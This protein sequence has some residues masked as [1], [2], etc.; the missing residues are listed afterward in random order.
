MEGLQTY[1]KL[2]GRHLALLIVISK[3]MPK[4]G[5]LRYTLDDAEIYE[6]FL[7]NKLGVKKEDIVTLIDEK[8]T[9][10]EIDYH[11]QQM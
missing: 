2:R 4:F 1:S 8:A 9:A 6:K 7:I 10:D 11:L 5:N 3:Y